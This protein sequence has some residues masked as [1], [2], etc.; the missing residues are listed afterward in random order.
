[1]KGALIEAVFSDALHELGFGVSKGGM[2]DGVVAV[3][4][5][6]FEQDYAEEH[7]DSNF[8]D[9]E[10]ELTCAVKDVEGGNRYSRHFAVRVVREFGGHGGLGMDLLGGSIAKNAAMAKRDQEGTIALY[11]DAFA[12]LRQQILED[13]ALRSALIDLRESP[14]TDR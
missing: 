9:A 3:S 2:A 13:E 6:R 12:E 4:I 14:R 1:L 8:R 10:L 5:Q 7:G 11:A